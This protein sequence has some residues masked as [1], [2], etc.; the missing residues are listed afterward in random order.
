MCIR[1][2]AFTVK[3]IVDNYP[4]ESITKLHGGKPWDHKWIKLGDKTYTLNNIEND[5]L[6]PQYKDARVH[7]A[8]N[9][10]AKSCPPLLNRAWNKR[11]VSS[12]YEKQAKAFVNNS[13]YNKISAD[14]VEI[15]KIFEWYAADFGDLITY[16]NKYSKTKINPGAKISYIEYDWKLN[17]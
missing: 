15:S 12:Y 3:L 11:N 16:L 6:R 8:V 1:D 7:F 14:K 4:L 2:S 13:N 17:E 9:C 10:A 5:I